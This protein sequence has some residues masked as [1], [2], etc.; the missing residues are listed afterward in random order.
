MAESLD[1]DRSTL[2]NYEFPLPRYYLGHRTGSTNSTWA[3]PWTTLHYW[4][5]NN[6]ASEFRR[7]WDWTVTA[8]DKHQPIT[9]RRY[10]EGNIAVMNGSRRTATQETHV[11]EIFD[12]GISAAHRIAISSDQNQQPPSDLHSTIQ[13]WENTVF[14]EPDYLLQNP[15]T[16]QVTG[17][18]E[19]KS[20]WNIGPSEIDDVITG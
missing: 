8:N 7:Y 16:Y 19:A 4:T 11:R 6:I 17:I 3:Q 2:L 9:W 20:P 5:P 18:C 15:I 10:I 14:G 13:S 1:C 12:K